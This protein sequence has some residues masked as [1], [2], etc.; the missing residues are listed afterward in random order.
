MCEGVEGNVLSLF[1]RLFIAPRYLFIT[2]L[3]P[4]HPV[5][6]GAEN[7]ANDSIEKFTEGLLL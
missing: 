4:T 5:N 2:S 6:L 1:A 7:I 3:V